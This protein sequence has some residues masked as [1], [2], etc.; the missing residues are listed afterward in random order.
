VFRA[1]AEATTVA[2][3][4]TVWARL[5]D[6][7]TWPDWYSGYSGASIDGPVQVGQHGTVVLTTGQSRP[8]EVYEMVEGHHL[9]F[10]TGAPGAKIRF[11]YG[12][13]GNGSGSSIALEHTLTGPL[14]GIF[15]AIFGRRIARILPEAA[16]QLATIA[17]R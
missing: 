15:A 1:H 12:V 9:T 11:I 10:G 4:A 2:P 6:V 3:A 7:S 8:F 16:S 5:Q 17:A 14:S 13:E